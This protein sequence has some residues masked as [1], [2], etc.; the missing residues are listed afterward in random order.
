MEVPLPGHYLGQ[1]GQ[2]TWA[3]FADVRFS[4]VIPI[5]FKLNAALMALFRQVMGDW[6]WVMGHVG[7]VGHDCLRTIFALPLEYLA[8][9]E[10]LIF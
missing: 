7:H 3:K 8:F 1:I 6:S 5:D 4:P 2:K 9:V 10:K